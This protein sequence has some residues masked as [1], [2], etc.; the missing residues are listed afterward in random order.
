MRIHLTFAALIVATA[1]LADTTKPA[2]E[3]EIQ[4]L[5]DECLHAT[6]VGDSS[7]GEKYFADDYVQI[8]LGGG[9]T[10]RQFQIDIKKTGAIKYERL[11]LQRRKVRIYGDTAVV[12]MESLA[13]YTVRGKQIEGLFRA[14]RVWVRT[15]GQWKIVTFQ[16]NKVD[17]P[18]KK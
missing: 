15:D 11:D 13:R 2:S 8:S 9:E 4:R 6:P 3:S 12:N 14:T 1:S 18:A 16:A 10:G 7:F 17:D 5:E